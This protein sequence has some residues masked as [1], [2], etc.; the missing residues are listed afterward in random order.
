MEEL[1][2]ERLK[3]GL[4]Q[5]EMAKK[6]KISYSHYSKLEGEF[7]NPSLKVLRKFKQE[8]PDADMNSFFKTKK[9]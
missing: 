4:K 9:A 3:H 5:T 8:F 2:R 1:K 6:L 7:A